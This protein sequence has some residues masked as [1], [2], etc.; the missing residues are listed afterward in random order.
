M[1]R[2][3]WTAAPAIIISLYLLWK[4]SANKTNKAPVTE[5]M[6]LKVVEGEHKKTSAASLSAEKRTKRKRWVLLKCKISVSLLLSMPRKK[7]AAI[8]PY[9]VNVHNLLKFL[10]GEGLKATLKTHKHWKNPHFCCFHRGQRQFFSLIKQMDLTLLHPPI[11]IRG[12]RKETRRHYDG[13]QLET[14]TSKLR[15]IVNFGTREAKAPIWKSLPYEVSILTFYSHIWALPWL[16]N[17]EI[18]NIHK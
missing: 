1:P 5:K 3:N 4:E 15:S 18:S 2:S 7:V 10:K 9:N 8:A 14:P 11:I 17:P 13:T 6:C 12:L 16:G